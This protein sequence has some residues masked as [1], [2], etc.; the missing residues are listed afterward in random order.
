MSLSIII[1]IVSYATPL[2]PSI[3]GRSLVMKSIVTSFYDLT[4]RVLKYK[5][6]YFAYRLDLFY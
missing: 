1:N 5:L 4:S 6:L 2:Y 3:E